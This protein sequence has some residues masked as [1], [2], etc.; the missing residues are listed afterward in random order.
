MRYLTTVSVQYFIQYFIQYFK[1]IKVRTKC[2]TIFLLLLTTIYL[3]GQDSNIG[4][5]FTTNYTNEVYQAGTQNW[6]IEQHPNG[7]LFFANNNGLLQFDG[8]NWQTFELPN[9]T[10]VRS[11]HISEDGKIYVGGQGEFGYFEP[12]NGGELLYHSLLAII[13]EKDRQFSDVWELINF[14]G[15]IYFNASD[16]IYEYANNRIKVYKNGKIKF[17]GK[18]HGRLFIGNEAGLFEIKD[19]SIIPV[20]EGNQL[21]TCSL[22]D[23]VQGKKG[24]LIFATKKNGLFELAE[25]GLVAKTYEAANFIKDHEVYCAIEVSEDRIALGMVGKGLILMN[26]AGKLLYHLNKQNGLQ[27]NNILNIFKD[28]DKN[29][30]LGLNNGIDHVLVNSPFSK[31][32]PDKEQEGTAY[33]A[34]IY[35][36]KLYLGTSNGLYQQDWQPYY[37]PLEQNDF[38]LLKKSKGQVWGL[39]QIDQEFFMGHHTG[40]FVLRQNQ[41]EEISPTY[42]T[43]TFLQLKN[44]PNYL[45]AGTYDGLELY[46]KAGVDWQFVKRYPDIKESCRIM[47]QDESENIWIAHPYRGTFKVQLTADLENIKVQF[48]DKQEGY[49]CQNLTIVN[50]EVI[51][52]GETGVFN[53]D[54][55]RDTFLHYKAFEDLIG[56]EKKPRNFF[57]DPI[58]NIWYTS[59]TET[60]ILKVEDAGLSK[61][62]HKVV[63]PTIHKKMV[64]GFEFIYP[65]DS[66]NVF[67]GTEKGFIHFNPA[68]EKVNNNNNKEFVANIVKVEAIHN[69]K[70]STL[71]FGQYQSIESTV[72]TAFPNELT[73]FRF[74]YTTP[75]FPTLK[76]RYYRTKLEGFDTNWSG[77]NE[78]TAK[79]YTNLDAGNYRF[80]VQAKSNQEQESQIASYIFSIKPPW[81]YGK[82]AIFLY[83]L[84]GFLLLMG[85]IFIPKK[86]FQKELAKLKSKQANLESKQANLESQQAIKEAE[87]QKLVTQSQQEINSL[88][89]KNLETE[90]VHKNKELAL[91]TMHLVQRNELILKLQEPL[92]QILRK[93][94][95]KTA[96]T[97]IKR[98][99]KLLKEDEKMGDSWDQFANHF[100]QVHVDFLQ[101][102]RQEYPQLTAND[103]KLCA[104]LRMN[105][106]TKEIAPLMNISIRGV[107][108]GR[109]RLRKK[110]GLD[111]TVNLTEFMI[112]I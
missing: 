66:H 42:G 33:T 97:E 57:E 28:K 58:G 16:K 53:Y 74:N 62:F 92:A 88:K 45:I 5:P 102:I 43:W 84:L 9:N 11:L 25:G 20:K 55:K 68:K 94:T 1:K 3:N 61:S 103:R 109:Y 56:K 72:R 77:W 90:I 30:W 98:I 22:V 86:R 47:V 108:V 34:G 49:P 7:F 10:V 99:N 112:A 39:N 69:N 23:V 54:A 89:N 80:L 106:S 96:I 15:T 8:T 26:K 51:F 76:K 50:K 24:R 44:Q 14:Q 6:D 65:Y 32:I 85:L 93:T 107:E 52:T 83:A 59:A 19:G 64:K 95:N 18:G 48:Y 81:Y 104:Y 46:Q 110:I 17:I 78:Q 13:P 40:G 36:N 91:T 37:H 35:N 63:Y 111:S 67:I 105:L 79:E 29:L 27:N 12:S 82:F 70:D 21:A 60:G 41:L 38:Q 4:I 75:N 100:D 101:R 73:A 2:F 87:H 71:L 31:I